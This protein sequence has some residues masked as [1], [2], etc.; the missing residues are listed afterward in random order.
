MLLCLSLP[1]KL[2]VFALRPQWHRLL[3]AIRSNGTHRTSMLA[4]LW[5]FSFA[6]IVPNIKSLPS[7]RAFSLGQWMFRLLYLTRFELGR[8][9]HHVPSTSKLCPSQD[10]HCTANIFG[11]RFVE[12]RATES[13]GWP[14]DRR[15][16]KLECVY[17]ANEIIILGLRSSILC[18]AQ[19]SVYE[20]PKKHNVS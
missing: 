15:A 1:L 2:I 5:Y 3:H 7:Y 11:S 4:S 14:E 13:L 18:S 17:V 9:A 8:G 20:T 12:W 16:L 19:V 6:A 10:W